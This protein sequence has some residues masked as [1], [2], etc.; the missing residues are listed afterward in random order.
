MS[1]LNEYLEKVCSEATREKRCKT[2]KKK[3][4]EGESNMN[5]G[6]CEACKSD[7]TAAA[8]RATGVQ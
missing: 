5:S 1:K 6:K 8:E 7:E 4:S 3:I 2:C